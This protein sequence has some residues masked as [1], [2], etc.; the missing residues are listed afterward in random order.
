[1]NTECIYPIKKIRKKYN[2]TQKK[3][4]D[5]TGIPMRTLQNWETGKRRC[6]EYTEKLIEYYV[7]RT[8]EESEAG[9]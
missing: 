8:I 3:L 1:M 7:K 9:T 5:M 6:P 4:S 2:L